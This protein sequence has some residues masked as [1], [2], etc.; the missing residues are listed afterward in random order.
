MGGT[1]SYGSPMRRIFFVKYY[2]KSS[3]VLGADQIGEGL[4]ARGLEARAV[5]PADLAGVRD[6]VL[7]FIKTSRLPDLVAARR[8]GN[9]T[10][11]DVQDTVV[12]KGGIKN[13]WLFDG[14][15]FKNRRQLQ[16]FGD[17]KRLCRIIPHQWDPRYQPNTAGEDA[18]RIG[19]FGDERSLPF[20]N[21]LPGVDCFS[22]NFFA[23]ALLYNCHLSFRA[24]GRDFLY[25]PNCKVST[26]AAC[27]A[28]LVTTRDESA[29]ELLGPDYPYYA[30]ATAEGLEATIGRV[31]ATFG[32]PEWRAGLERMRD[33]REQTHLGRVLDEY[34]AY[35]ADLA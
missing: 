26:A 27:G 16:D 10:V 31:R 4:R 8:R 25:K 20:W 2:D 14:L 35:F 22:G 32:G 15:L 29:V 3:T 5:Y 21:R 12:F 19:Y 28:N 11:L 7:V 34:M 1:I 30:E 9:R 13:R 23:N 33:V 6:A 18:P 17:A 24:P